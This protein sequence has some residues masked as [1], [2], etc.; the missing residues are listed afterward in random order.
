MPRPTKFAKTFRPKG[1]PSKIDRTVLPAGNAEGQEFAYGLHA[2]REIL[3]AGSRSLLRL[4]VIRQDAQFT[5][6]VRLARSQGVPIT[7][8]PRERINR[9]IS[10]VNH[11]GIVGL[12]AAKSY[13]DEDDLLDQ[14]TQR[15]TPTLIIVLD[16]I[17]DPQNLGAIL[18]TADAAGVQGIFIPKHRSVGLTGGVARASAGAIEY[19]QVAR[20]GNTN[21]LLEKLHSANV[22]TCALDPTGK[23]PY[24]ALDLTSPTALIFGAE[25]EG[26]RPGVLK[27]CDQRTNIPMM[28]Q[29]DSLNLSASV[30]V[31]LFEAMRQRREAGK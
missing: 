31:V 15:K 20:A 19:V 23:T 7:V 6:I 18:R 22:M 8:E 14:V 13:A 9:L 12:V 21:R 29:I 26:I 30:A 16:S 3:R 4:H 25:G 10:D 11:Q 17:Q 1:S 24:T 2:L 5:E 28:G 27:K